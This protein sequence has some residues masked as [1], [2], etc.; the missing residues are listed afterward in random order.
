MFT[1]IIFRYGSLGNHEYGYNVTAQVDYGKINKNWI[2]PD[3]YYSTRILVDSDTLTYISLIVL[4]TSPCIS[5][6]RGTNPS[7][8]D[9]CS[10]T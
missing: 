6:Y 10:T 8:Y 9:P 5:D 1:I 7:Y 3:R 2:L 4:D